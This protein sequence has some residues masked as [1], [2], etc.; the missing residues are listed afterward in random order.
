M[1]TKIMIIRRVWFHGLDQEVRSTNM[2]QKCK[3]ISIRV[4]EIDNAYKVSD[5]YSR[6]INE[7]ERCLYSTRIYL[8]SY[9][10]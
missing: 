1:W 9:M 3:D 2:L 4:L 7:M 5:K 6:S 10:A 8:Y